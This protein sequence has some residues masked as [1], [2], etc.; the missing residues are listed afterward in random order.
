MSYNTN[1]PIVSNGLVFY[2]DTFN[3]KSYPIGV[4]TQSS[5][6]GSSY[7]GFAL[8]RV[9]DNTQQP[10]TF[11]LPGNVTTQWNNIISLGGGVVSLDLSG[12]A[13]P[14]TYVVNNTL[15]DNTNNVTILYPNP[16]GSATMSHTCSISPLTYPNPAI[17]NALRIEGID[18][19][20]IFWIYI[21]NSGYS[22]TFSLSGGPTTSTI[23]STAGASYGSASLNR[24]YDNT[25]QP[26][27]IGVPGNIT[28]EWS[29]I[30]QKNLGTVSIHASGGVTPEVYNINNAG[31]NS[32]NDTTFLFPNPTINSVT[33]SGTCSIDNTQGF[34]PTN[35]VKISGD[36]NDIFL[37]YLNPNG[38]YGGTLSIGLTGGA[39]PETFII[40]NV[41]IDGID[42]T[43]LADTNTYIGTL[44][45]DHT[46]FQIIVPEIIGTQ[47]T[48]NT[49]FTY[50]YYTYR[51]ESYVIQNVTFDSVDTFLYDN[52]NLGTLF[53]TH[54]DLQVVVPN[55]LGTQYT[56][57]TNFTYS[58][59]INNIDDMIL[60]QRGMIQN[61]V[62]FDGKDLIFDSVNDYIDFGD[63]NNLDGFLDYS[64]S[65][66]VYINT[67]TTYNTILH[68]WSYAYYGDPTGPAYF[69]GIM[70][71]YGIN[72]QVTVGENYSNV[73]GGDTGNYGSVSNTSLEANRWYHITYTSTPNTR[74]CYINGVLDKTE[75]NN[76]RDGNIIN[77]TATLKMGT[78]YDA[79]EY[80]NC[81]INNA[82]IYNRELTASEV[83]QNYNALKSRFI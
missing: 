47:Y 71:G 16:T 73:T 66:W 26:I 54:T 70:N 8:N 49:N 67:F 61:G 24:V 30:I 83:L 36:L 31:Y 4:P 41:F 3:N 68:K 65:V 63:S 80:T 52:M 79:P 11:A 59:I 57:N 56:D 43:I 60:N 75:V 2:V 50:S 1:N 32:Y 19:Q 48:D 40:D 74:S 39:I 78:H 17:T 46:N 62:G 27:F 10:I 35:W 9:Y 58:Y 42:S 45:T 15:I 7:S 14:E 38:G 22:L 76:W 77:S 13:I 69:L 18:L 55:I 28:T 37:K 72:K 34:P 51:N 6:T 5:G 64:L 23:G 44:Y 33:M 21:L 53:D 81:K 82:A 29:N 25:Q 12:G 20:N